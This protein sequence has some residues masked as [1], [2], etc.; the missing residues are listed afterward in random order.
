MKKYILF[1]LIG[2]VALS[3]RKE[4]LDKTD[5]PNLTDI[6]GV[7]DIVTP[8]VAS[9]S[10]VNFAT[11][12]NVYFTCELSKIVNWKLT[13][14]GQTSGAEKVIEGTSKELNSS[15][16]TWNG[17]TTSFPMFRAETCSVMLTF[18][19]QTDTLNTVITVD[20]P[21]LN[22]G[23]VVADFESGWNNGWSTFIQS[24]ANMDFSIKA[25]GT[26]PEFDNYYNMQGTVD[27]DWLVGLV[28]FNASAYGFQTLPLTDNSG[29]LYFNAL[30]YGEAGLPNSL[31]LFRFDEDENEDGT[32]T[33][34]SEDQY[35]YEIP[36]DWVGWRLISIKYS[37]LTGNGN[38]GGVH[39]PDK[40]NK[41]S[42]LHLADPS[43]GFAKSGIDYIIF[44]ENAA[45]NP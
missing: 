2:I 4:E 35:G 17:S 14:T 45:L 43:S 7:F 30:V 34:I 6:Y 5:G 39:N 16:A 20:Q 1:L 13:I 32:F 33:E 11:G 29:N 42:V 36:V 22:A 10:N 9:Q 15:N 40:L 26:S 31:I 8:L 19:G 23:F 25:D 21:K 37:D 44:T 27:W 41:V 12:Q 28:D 3:C 24:G 18:E 38:G